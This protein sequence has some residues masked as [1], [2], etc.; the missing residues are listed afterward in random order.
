MSFSSL[1]VAS[2]LGFFVDGDGCEVLFLATEI[3]RHPG[4]TLGIKFTQTQG[5]EHNWLFNK[6]T[7]GNPVG[8]G[9]R[10]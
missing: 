6:G 1:V 9:W 2:G 7:V 10:M 3:V 5:L 4:L 8:I